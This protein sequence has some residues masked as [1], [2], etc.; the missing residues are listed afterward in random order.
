MTQSPTI[1]PFDSFVMLK[2]VN[3]SNDANFGE[4]PVSS[5]AK[6]GRRAVRRVDP[7]VAI[8][9]WTIDSGLFLGLGQ[10]LEQKKLQPCLT[11]FLA[12]IW[13]AFSIQP[14]DFLTYVSLSD[15]VTRSIL[16]VSTF[17]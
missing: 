13:R 6:A 17:L 2:P 4:N 12:R 3:E 10:L 1:K 16:S 14:M 5:K 8:K 7:G 9:N 15:D 11:L